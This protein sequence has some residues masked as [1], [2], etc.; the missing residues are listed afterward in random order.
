VS[1]TPYTFAHPGFSGY[2]G[3]ARE[4][5][6]PPVGIYNRN[7]GASVH[8]VAAGIHR[9]LTLTV[10]T[11]QAEKDGAPLILAAADLGWWRDPKDE[12]Y[13]RG[14]LLDALGLDSARFLFN[15]SHTHA[16][17]A[18]CRDDADNPGGE[19]IA[20]YLDSLRH[21]LIATTRRALSRAQPAML[22]FAYGKCGLAVN[23]D[24]PAPA[25]SP[26]QYLCGFN[27]SVPA[28]DTLL[29]GRVCNPDATI[30][31]TLV[32]YACH[33]TTL[34]HENHML[35]PDFVGGMAEVIES[36]TKADCLFLQGA[37]GELAPRS[38][39]TS[40]LA[41]AEKNGATLG[42]AAYGTLRGMIP[43]GQ[44]LA[45]EKA[46]PSGAPLAIWK[47]TP[48]T[49]SSALAAVQVEV[50]MPIKPEWQGETDEE[51]QWAASGEPALLERLH[52]RRRTRL[53]LGGAATAKMPLWAWR[54]GNALFIGHPN[55][56]YSLLQTELRA[57]FPDT[58]VA[59]M[60]VTNGW[61]GYLPP[62]DLYGTDIYPVWQTPFAP[63]CLELLIAQ[64]KA[65][66]RR[67]LA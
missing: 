45:Y 61:Y 37:S 14:A 4:D 49:Y 7:W 44:G 64:S 12:W 38:Q 52:R 54:V 42:Y 66:A 53:A 65:E 41:A 43:C 17:P 5:I 23:R 18:L 15:F 34:A 40:L 36:R 16:G 58:A 59:V 1:D 30:R 27:P 11:L 25:T 28:D 2:I 50:E 20:P 6:T 55:E 60:N 3:V 46:V 21:D 62:A 9:P 35:S 47:L 8:D 10:L 13:V 19:F 48:H 63:G 22:D 31:A 29:F 24:M 51:R 56:A 33:P 32:N 39:Y 67:L 57:A 26:P